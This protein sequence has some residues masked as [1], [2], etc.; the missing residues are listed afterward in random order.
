VIGR[1]N[2]ASGKSSYIC[3]LTQKETIFRDIQLVS[4]DGTKKVKKVIYILRDI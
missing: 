3:P 2:F 1:I 4:E